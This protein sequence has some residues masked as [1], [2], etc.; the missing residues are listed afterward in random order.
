MKKK[1]SICNVA[2]LYLPTLNLINAAERFDY[3]P[4]S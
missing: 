1:N 4:Q 3:E 2:F